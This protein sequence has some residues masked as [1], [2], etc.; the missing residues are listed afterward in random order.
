MGCSLH[1]ALQIFHLVLFSSNLRLHDLPKPG[2]QKSPLFHS[3][4]AKPLTPIVCTFK[5]LPSIL[6]KI[7]L[8]LLFSGASGPFVLLY[9]KFPH[10][11]KNDDRENHY[12]FP[13]GTSFPLWLPPQQFPLQ[14][15]AIFSKNSQTL[16]AK[17]LGLGQRFEAFWG[18]SNK[19][20][21]RVCRI[22]SLRMCTP[23]HKG[24]SPEPLI[25]SQKSS[26]LLIGLLGDRKGQGWGHLKSN[27][28]QFL[29]M[30]VL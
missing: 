29:K 26:P 25:L 24:T 9:K 21:G 28:V 14:S 23:I 11:R 4:L 27:Q 6:G 20:P 2:L 13:K 5:Y 17:N 12:C 19:L 1:Q 3:T 15:V 7:P 22:S 18:T 8:P 16:C 10:D 30:L